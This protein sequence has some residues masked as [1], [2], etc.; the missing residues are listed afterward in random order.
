MVKE[1]MVANGL[2]ESDAKTTIRT[3]KK[4]EFVFVFSLDPLYLFILFSPKV[5]GG[6]TAHSEII[7]YEDDTKIRRV[8]D[9]ENRR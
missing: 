5:P 7:V 9:I 4:F 6:M 1:E 8:K 2:M 3:V